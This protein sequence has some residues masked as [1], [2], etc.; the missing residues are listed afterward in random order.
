M[1]R[2]LPEEEIRKIAAGEVI[3]RPASVVKELIENSLDAG[4]L[5]VAVE[6][7]GAGERLIRVA[8]SGCGMSREDA[9]LALERLP[10]A[11]SLEPRTSKASPRSGSGERPCPRS[12]LW[13][14]WSC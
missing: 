11:R 14:K 5:E 6:I 3:E 10:R 2:V 1:I 4:A 9:L 8:D 13:R 7:E 12:A